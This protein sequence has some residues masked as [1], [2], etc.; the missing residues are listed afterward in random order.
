MRK[1]YIIA[2]W[3]SVLNCTVTRCSLVARES[4]CSR[5]QRG[6]CGSRRQSFARLY[7]H[8]DSFTLC[9]QQC[10][11]GLCHLQMMT[12]D[13]GHASPRGTEGG[14]SQKIINHNPDI[15]HRWDMLVPTVARH[16]ALGGQCR[17]GTQRT[18][19]RSR[20]S[21]SRAALERLCGDSDISKAPD[22]IP[23]YFTA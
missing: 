14:D 6:V 8:E 19:P 3:S 1:C 2:R 18:F 11:H 16:R 20:M 7:D 23:H 10:C 13:R 21:Y 17:F 15:R 22:V 4:T 12:L 5:P 9:S